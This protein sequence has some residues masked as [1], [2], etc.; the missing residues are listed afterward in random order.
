[1]TNYEKKTEGAL[2]HL[3]QASVLEHHVFTVPGQAFEKS[4]KKNTKTINVVR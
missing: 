1:M 3:V 4:V 2:A